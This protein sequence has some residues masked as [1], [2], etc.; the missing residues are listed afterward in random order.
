MPTVYR[1]RKTPYGYKRPFT[2]R[3]TYTL[4]QRYMGRRLT[5]FARR[6]T[7]TRGGKWKFNSRMIPGSKMRALHID[8]ALQSSAFP[9]QLG[10]LY[11]SNFKWPSANTTLV[12]NETIDSPRFTLRGI[13]INRQFYYRPFNQVEAKSNLGPLV[14]NYAIMQIKEGSPDDLA[15]QSVLAVDFF[16]DQTTNSQNRNFTPYGLGTVWSNSFNTCPIN[17]NGPFRVLT[18]K[19]KV[20]TSMNPTGEMKSHMWHMNKYY[21]FNKPMEYETRSDAFPVARIFEVFW[22]NTLTN[23]TN[24][25]FAY[26]AG[27]DPQIYEPIVS[28]HYHK[29]YY[30]TTV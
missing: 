15:L 18:H 25:V 13:R 9:I 4:K 27:V 21:A 22:C 11:F 16:K 5:R 20:M 24:G 12:N 1:K 6:R 2:G 23:D 8:S 26:G 7:Y 30:K 19:R 14:M 28:T 10:N 29:T 3:K 17:N